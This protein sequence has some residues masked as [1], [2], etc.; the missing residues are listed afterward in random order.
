MGEEYGVDETQPE[1]WHSYFRSHAKFITMCNH[2]LDHLEQARLKK[3]IKT[4]G[5]QRATRPQDI[6]DDDEEEEPIFDPMVVA[7]S[8]AEGRMM[9]KWLGAARTRLGGAFPRPAAREQMEAYARKRRER[10][11]KGG[12]KKPKTDSPYDT[13]EEETMK[14][15]VV[16]V[17]AASKALMLLWLRKAREKKDVDDG[18]KAAAIR[19]QVDDTLGK[20]QEEDD[21]FYGSELR[22]NGKALV[23]EGITLTE[24][25]R[26][27][28]A[29]MAVKLRRIEEDLTKFSEEKQAEMNEKRDAFDAKWE[30]E[31]AL[32]V[33][34]ADNRVQELAAEHNI[35]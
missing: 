26:S 13:D 35:L 2:C 8:S 9:S 17:N 22:I 30:R 31:K 21:W 20:M 1:L 27:L 12:K 34:E 29:E 32:V 18:A 4:P 33:E 10:K 19:K 11:E 6:S 24:D 28:E 25:Q 23:K 14:K 15:W 3:L 7:R 16:N 5:Q